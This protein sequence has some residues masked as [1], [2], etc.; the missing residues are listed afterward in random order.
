MNETIQ[1]ELLQ[2]SRLLQSPDAQAIFQAF[3]NKKKG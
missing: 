2:F 3:L 1:A